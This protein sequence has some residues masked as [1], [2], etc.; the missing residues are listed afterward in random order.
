MNR[1]LGL[2]ILLIGSVLGTRALCEEP[3]KSTGNDEVAVARQVG[4]QAAMA[5]VS[6]LSSNRPSGFPG[7]EAWLTDF[8]KQTKGLDPKDP[9]EKWPMVD[10]DALAT[11]N[12][13]FWRAYYEIAPGD[14]GAGFLYAGMLVGCSE[15]ERAK[16]VI[17][18]QLLRPGM[19]EGVRNALRKLWTAA[20]KGCAKSE[21]LVKEGI[22]LFD[23][24]DYPAAVNKYREALKVWP[25]NGWA[26]YEL[27][28]TLRIQQLIAAGEPPDTPEGDKITLRVDNP[29]DLKVKHSSEVIDA[30]A[31][32]RRY[33]PFLYEAY[34]GKDQELI[35][36]HFVL[37]RS[38]LPALKLSEAH[39]AGAV[40]QALQFLAESCQ[41]IGI[42][43]FA[44]IA[45]QIIVA[46]RGRYHFV[47]H[48]FIVTSLRKLAPG[49]DT[50]A[51][52]ERL[53][54]GNTAFY[55]FVASEDQ[56]AI[57]LATWKFV[58]AEPKYI[59][60]K[61]S[62][63]TF[64][65]VVPIQ[66][67]KTDQFEQ[68]KLHVAFAT[69]D[70]PIEWPLFDLKKKKDD[71]LVQIRTGKNFDKV[72]NPTDVD[73]WWEVRSDQQNASGT[74]HSLFAA[75][76][77]KAVGNNGVMKLGFRGLPDAEIG[78]FIKDDK[79][80]PASNVLMFQKSYFRAGDSEELF[81]AA[82]AKLPPDR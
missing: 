60:E 7:I 58:M 54:G 50:E 56:D 75:P 66:V 33:D 34:Q 68:I 26:Y 19:A 45:R 20:K 23:N 24:K 59:K 57:Q 27:G 15:C 79:S 67:Q 28:Y 48:P 5:M 49:P 77:Y 22:K 17:Q 63:D 47:D 64:T 13:H 18:L 39:D 70:K 32:S 72:K 51:V 2:P 76:E 74:A 53:A 82:V 3:A 80:Q 4:W 37:E 78:L 62:D 71:N 31:K 8:A 40:D 11:H 44:L 29:V 21:A 61:N 81:K 73:V 46:R 10:V 52:L 30:F 41:G 35:L 55:R 36:G 42:H 38:I 6:H 25:Q 16:R 9:P 14:P 43:D 1:G 65:I 69:F 12:S